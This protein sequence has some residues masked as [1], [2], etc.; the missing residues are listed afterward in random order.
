[1]ARKILATSTGKLLPI[2]DLSLKSLQKVVGGYIEIVTCLAIGYEEN[3]I[4]CNEEGRL[5]SLPPNPIASRMAGQNIVGDAVIAHRA[6]TLKKG[7]DTIT[8]DPIP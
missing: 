2:D 3:V 4:I 5:Q 8:N 1:M 6:E 7:I